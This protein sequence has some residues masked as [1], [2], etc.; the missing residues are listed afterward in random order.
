MV[1]SACRSSASASSSSSS[2][3]A[4]RVTPLGLRRKR[5]TPISSSRSCTCRLKAG[6]AMRSLVAALVKLRARATATKYRKWRNSMSRIPLCRKGM[7]AR[8]VVLADFRSAKL[9]HFNT[10][11]PFAINNDEGIQYAKVGR[12]S[13]GHYGRRQRYRGLLP[14]SALSKREPTSSLRCA[15]RR[16]WIRPLPKSAAM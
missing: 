11:N 15:G 13:G 7:D 8:K 4:V 16:S 14:P 5:S 6:W 1:L 9:H 10:N 12:K 3:S 2:P